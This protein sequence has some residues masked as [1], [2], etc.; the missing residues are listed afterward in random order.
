MN[1]RRSNRTITYLML[2]IS[3]I[4][5][6]VVT[7]VLFT[8]ATGVHLRSG[9]DIKA[10]VSDSKPD[11]LVAQRGLIKDRNGNV[12]ASDVDTYML[13]AFLDESRKDGKKDAYVKDYKK[14]AE[15]LAPILGMDAQEIEGI[16]QS[17]KDKKYYQTQFGT[18]GKNLSILDK[19]KIEALKLPGLG[20][21]KSSQ[22]NYTYGKFAS[23][24]LG[25]ARFNEEEERI[26]GEM[27]LEATL[28]KKLKGS[29]G[30]VRYKKDVKG[31]I[32][33]PKYVEKQAVN[34][35]DVTL[36]LDK[37]VQLALESA[38]DKTMSEFN[39]DR[40][41]GIVMEV[42]TGKILGWA[43]YPTFDLN[44]KDILD[45]RDI[46]SDYAYEPGSTM[47]VFTYAAAMDTGVYDGSKLFQSGTFNWK[48][49]DTGFVRTPTM[50]NASFQ[51]ISDAL[52]KNWGMISYDQGLVYSANTGICDL[53]TNYLEPKVLEDYL[54]KFGFFQP[55]DTYGINETTTG[56]KNFT[57]P[58]DQLSLGFGQ[59]SSVTALQM[60][61][62]YTAI[63]N[64]GE[65]LK[66]YYIDKITDG[67]NPDKVI[68]EGK[69]EVLGNPV[70][71]ETT[72]QLIELMDQVVNSEGGSG[73]RYHMDDVQVIAKTGTAQIVT[74]GKYGWDTYVNSVMA[75]APKDDPKIM[76]YYAFESGAMLTY[77]GDYFKEVFREALVAANIAG[78][79]NPTMPQEDMAVNDWKEFVMPSFVNHSLTYATQKLSTMNV[80]PIIIGDGKS[81]VRQFPSVNSSIMSKQKI[82]LM[83]DGG[84]IKMPNMIG[85][86]RKDVATFWDMSGISIEISGNGSV[87]EQSIPVDT[88]IN[89]DSEISVKL[90]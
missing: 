75:A 90:K 28:D 29:D 61:Q 16:L 63:F 51:P 46:P 62:A 65:M 11:V 56:Y 83:S 85:W 81:V 52:G 2:I 36:T 57:Y 77:T 14:T 80:N 87:Y 23:H 4:G 3:I 15:G 59:G 1:T 21:E 19:E 43:G 71:K 37:N 49:D 18:K 89:K 55:V 54:K 17:G 25:Y 88:L 50:E 76:M 64:D 72:D 60:V 58:A 9:T 33:G 32:L 13:I 8:I 79:S 86:T 73:K 74:D 26:I 39:S 67:S 10:A 6:L 41:W 22:R 53:I 70:K 78:T 45:H 69:K 31:N 44:E 38:L 84:V 20:F 42:E 48:Y 27:G 34:G 66:P 47:K 82:F 5:A 7:N 40:A 68:Y 35:D 12:L 24:L 30:A